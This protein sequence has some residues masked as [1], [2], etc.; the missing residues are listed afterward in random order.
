[1]A[2]KPEKEKEKELE[3]QLAEK[4]KKESGVSP[5]A[6]TET[7][8]REPIVAPAA[9]LSPISL[10]EDADVTNAVQELEAGVSEIFRPPESLPGQPASGWGKLNAS[11][12]EFGRSLVWA[13]EKKAE[14]QAR[15]QDRQQAEAFGEISS[16]V[17]FREAGIVARQALADQS[18]PGSILYNFKREKLEAPPSLPPATEQDWLNELGLKRAGGPYNDGQASL[19][20]TEGSTLPVAANFPGIKPILPV[21]R[22]EQPLREFFSIPEPPAVADPKAA[23]PQ[24]AEDLE[25]R[26]PRFGPG[27][28]NT[29]KNGKIIDEAEKIAKENPGVSAQEIGDTF[30]NKGLPAESAKR[31]DLIKSRIAK[32]ESLGGVVS[33]DASDEE[34]TTAWRGKMRELNEAGLSSVKVSSDFQKALA[35][36]EAQARKRAKP[37]AAPEPVDKDALYERTKRE[38]IKAKA[39]KKYE[40]YS[41]FK[42]GTIKLEGKGSRRGARV[43]PP[44]RRQQEWNIFK[45]LER[46]DGIDESKVVGKDG[47]IN[48]GKAVQALKQHEAD[49]A[50]EAERLEEAKK[51]ADLRGVKKRAEHVIRLTELLGDTEKPTAKQKAALEEKRMQA[52]GNLSEMATYAGG[53]TA[54]LFK[55]NIFSEDEFNTAVDN[56]EIVADLY[57]SGD[58]DAIKAW[59]REGRLGTDIIP[60]DQR[61]F[62]TTYARLAKI[63]RA[64]EKKTEEE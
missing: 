35:A 41:W 7:P 8:G 63:S 12:G 11:L 47:S 55:M 32:L 61:N 64:G 13:P 48:Y 16:G 37:G 58:L 9:P 59:E 40:E 17:P 52:A 24:L 42:N 6:L 10:M 33:K 14:V 21:L 60:V 51:Y 22:G 34:V 27:T 50:R 29:F 54:E 30:N 3:V 46:T 49:K 23:L 53:D 1:M 18:S 36:R 31:S 25:A 26:R 56:A 43:K 39:L 20:R 2:L 4:A 28:S 5:V 45:E 15:Y 44:T 19:V 57:A 62:M 38:L